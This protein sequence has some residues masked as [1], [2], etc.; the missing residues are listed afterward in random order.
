MA[1]IITPYLVSEEQCK[2]VPA[3][4]FLALLTSMSLSIK[5][6]T[7]FPKA[8]NITRSEVVRGLSE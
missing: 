5:I 2:V 6:G 1:T 8:K 3:K 7:A 4:L